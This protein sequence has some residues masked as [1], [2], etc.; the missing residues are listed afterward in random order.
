[1]LAKCGAGRN[2]TLGLTTMISLCCGV[3]HLCGFVIVPHMVPKPLISA[4]SPLETAIISPFKNAL[5]T[6]RAWTIVTSA[7]FAASSASVFF[8]IDM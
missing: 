5:T 7:S 8:Q 6:A 1:M 3:V 4:G 2:E